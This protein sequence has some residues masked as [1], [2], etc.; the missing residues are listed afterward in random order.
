MLELAV[1]S[2]EGWVADWLSV[3]LSAASSASENGNSCGGTGA[4]YCCCCCCCPSLGGGVEGGSKPSSEGAAC[5]GPPSLFIQYG[6]SD[7]GSPGV[8]VRSSPEACARGKAVATSTSSKVYAMSLRV[9][10]HVLPVNY[11]FKKE[12]FIVVREAFVTETYKLKSLPVVTSC[13]SLSIHNSCTSPRFQTSSH[14]NGHC[15][16]SYWCGETSI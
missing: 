13:S 5:A 15:L 10:E 12:G 7:S 4:W 16:W 9:V 8:Q 2:F 3:A 14:E 1:A 6:R 11:Y